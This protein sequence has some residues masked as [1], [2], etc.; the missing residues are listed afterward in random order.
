MQESSS[1]NHMATKISKT[2][3][4]KC[5]TTCEKISIKIYLDTRLYPLETRQHLFLTSSSPREDSSLEDPFEIS[6][7]PCGSLTNF[8]LHYHY[9]FF[10]ISTILAFEYV[11]D[12]TLPKSFVVRSMSEV[13]VELKIEMNNLGAA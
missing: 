8:L 2:L 3:M 1:A 12:G 7:S 5:L 4:E 11:D 13:S 9:S 10:F 6:F